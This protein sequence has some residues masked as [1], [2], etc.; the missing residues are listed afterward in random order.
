[1]KKLSFLIIGLWAIA[2]L[3]PNAAQ[4]AKEPE[5]SV[6]AEV[7]QAFLTI[8]D[9][10]EYSVTIRHAPEVQVLTT[11]PPPDS[12][13]LKI[14]KVQDIKQ[15]D[16]KQII[17]GR[18]FTLTTFQLGEYVLD[19]V[20]IE[21]RSGGDP[22]GEIKTISTDAIYLTVKSVAA[23]E[24]KTDIRGAKSVTAIKINLM[25]VITI[26]V[27]LALILAGFILYRI[28]KKSPDF[29][30]PSEPPMSPEEEAISN[31]NQLFDSDFLRRGKVKEYYLRFSEIL[32]VYLEKRVGI[33]AAELTTYEINRS[34][35]A[36]DTDIAFRE[37]V[38]EVLEAADLAKFA[39]WKPEPTEILALNQKAKE[40]IEAGR[41]KDSQ[42]AAR[43]V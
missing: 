3:A 21:Y 2:A 20:K 32:R 39:K 35:R 23:G 11:V 41:P 37:K 25:P 29:L 33:V 10:V 28:F 24:E 19:P 40:V 12:E 1:M 13:I 16:G 22:K 18:K 8:G 26:A 31:L 7:N 5:I 42:E 30:K 36:K 14:K 43:G 4:A 15:K 27:I 6:K 17:E 9:P 38:T 34:L